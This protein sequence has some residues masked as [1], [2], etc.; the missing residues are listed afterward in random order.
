[1]WAYGGLAGCV[2][3]LRVYMC[4]RGAVW[5]PCTI[6]VRYMQYMD[7]CAKVCAA[8][9]PSQLDLEGGQWGPQTTCST[10]L[11]MH[12]QCLWE[13]TWEGQG[14]EGFLEADHGLSFCSLTL[15][16]V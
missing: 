11:K 14:K 1:M 3:S 2:C 16:G 8:T 9:S 4:M 7:A 12:F 13:G 6:T 15:A 10:S 5:H